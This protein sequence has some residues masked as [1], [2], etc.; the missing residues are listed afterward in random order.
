MNS[1]SPNQPAT[2]P[3]LGSDSS[4]PL[5]IPV[6]EEQVHVDKVTDETGRVRIS[7]QVFDDV[8]Q[9]NT[10][11]NR[12][13]IDVQRVPVN[14]V[15]EAA[16]VARYEGDTYIIPVVREEVV[17]SIRYV[18]VEEIRVTKRQFQVVD[19]QTVTLRREAVTVEKIPTTS[20]L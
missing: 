13:E 9:V 2:E 18:L 1:S 16:P 8:E 19:S 6:I 11:L 4:S 12:E 10:L 7:K 3:K 14:Q 20:N 15:V 5:V 17:T